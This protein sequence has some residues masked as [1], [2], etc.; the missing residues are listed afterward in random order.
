M[1]LPKCADVSEMLVEGLEKSKSDHRKYFVKVMERVQYLARQGI[2]FLGSNARDDNVFQ[3]LLLRGKDNPVI[4]DKIKNDSTKRIY[5]YIHADYQQ[6]LLTIMATQVLLK[7]LK[8]INHNEMFSLML[9]EWTSICA[10][11]VDDFLNVHE[12]FLRSE[13]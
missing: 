5:K 4:L 12:N 7:V 10:R 9:D 6:E 1:T 2:P 11:T 8:P 3:L 13:I